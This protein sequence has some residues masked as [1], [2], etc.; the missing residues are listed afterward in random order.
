MKS[1]SIPSLTKKAVK[2][3]NRYIRLKYMDKQT[4][5]VKCV[6]C[7]LYKS[8]NDIDAGHYHKSNHLHVKFNELNVHPQC[9]ACNHFRDGNVSAYALFLTRTYGKDI[10][11]I[12]EGLKN[13]PQ[14]SSK[15]KRYLME[16]IIETYSKKTFDLENNK[17]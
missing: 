8:F 11:E 13:R 2:I 1:I 7:N 16:G 12:L 14:M 9:T 5:L 6:T 15:E 4:R 3:F 10:L 17:I